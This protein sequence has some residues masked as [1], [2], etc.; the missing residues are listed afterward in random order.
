M[1]DR[2]PMYQAVISSCVGD[3]T[4]VQLTARRVGGG[5]RRGRGSPCCGRRWRS[6]AVS[7]CPPC[8][9]CA[10]CAGSAGSADCAATWPTRCP[11]AA[12]PPPAPRPAARRCLRGHAVRLAPLVAGDRANPVVQACSYPECTAACGRTSVSP[13]ILCSGSS[14]RLPRPAGR[15]PPRRQRW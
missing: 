14:I 9:P 10:A 7:R 6:P 8:G 11:G 12:P 1:S 4:G 5:G 2:K 3:T 15:T 13:S